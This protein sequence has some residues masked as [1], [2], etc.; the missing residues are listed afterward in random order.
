MPPTNAPTPT[1]AWQRAGAWLWTL[2]ADG[3]VV[4]EVRP[5][6][7]TQNAQGP[8]WWR[9]LATGQEGTAPTR[10]A[11]QRAARHAWKALAHGTTD[12]P[13][14]LRPAAALL[15]VSHMTVKAMLERG[16]LADT[17]PATLE[18]LKARGLTPNRGGRPKGAGGGRHSI[19]VYAPDGRRF[20]D[21]VAAAARQLDYTTRGLRNSGKVEPYR[22]G[23][24][25]CNLT[26]QLL[27]RVKG[28]E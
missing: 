7:G 26:P 21:S 12:K 4:A 14:S 5:R 18:A 9:L 13:L 8:H 28:V 23:Y 3:A 25:L 16:E 19:P 24:R 11:A 17:R 22:D 2:C 6:L 27:R 1:P 15:G 10:Y 20:A